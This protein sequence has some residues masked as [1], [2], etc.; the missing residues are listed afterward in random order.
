MMRIGI[1]CA[2]FALATVGGR[3][4]AQGTSQDHPGQY[5]AGEIE[6]GSRLYAGQCALCHGPNGDLVAAVDLRRGRFRRAVSDEDL[7]RVIAAG[8]PEAGMPGFTLQPSEVNGLIAFIRAG[9][10]ISG[11]AVKVGHAGRG[12][13]LFDGKGACGTCHRVNGKGPRVA[14]ELSDVGAIRTPAALQRSLLD[15]TS[16][17]L[18]INRPVRAVT[19]DGRTVKGR[20]LNEDTYSVQL[21]D[22]QERLVS[23]VK[24]DLREYELATTSPMPSYAATFNSDEIADLIAYL[25][26]LK[27]T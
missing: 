5:S 19:R 13:A 3:L 6:A 21:I 25:L 2:A 22:E 1:L 10:D 9:F 17:M 20:R 8:V 16:A 14:P 7:G 11:A 27:G 26:S 24:A 23:L 15:P 18:P 4:V 12:Q